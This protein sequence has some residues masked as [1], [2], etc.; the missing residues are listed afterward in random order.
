MTSPVNLGLGGDWPLDWWRSYLW[1][2]SGFP[3]N[4]PQKKSP[5]FLTMGVGQNRY[6][7]NGPLVSGH[8]D[9]NLWSNSWWFNF[10]PHPH[11]GLGILVSYKRAAY[12]TGWTIMTSH[13]LTPNGGLRG[14]QPRNHLVSGWWNIIFHPDCS[15]SNHSQASFLPVWSFQQAARVIWLHPVHGAKGWLNHRKPQP[16]YQFVVP[17]RL[18]PFE[19]MREQV[20][21]GTCA[22]WCKFKLWN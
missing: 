5:L 10:D 15:L 17:Q 9:Q 2:G 18:H 8:M 6:T 14:D 3:F 13:D 21:A 4:S 12:Y 19:A 22:H 20:D 1:F 16:G 7:Q 11:R